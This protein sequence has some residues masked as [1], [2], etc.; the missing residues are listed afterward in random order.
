VEISPLGE[1]DNHFPKERG[2]FKKE[3]PKKQH[4]E[5]I[6]HAKEEEEEEPEELKPIE[7]KTPIKKQ[8]VGTKPSNEN[9]SGSEN[10][11]KKNSENS[12]N[13]KSTS[14]KSIEDSYNPEDE[15]I[16][17]RV[18][19]DKESR[20]KEQSKSSLFLKKIKLGKEEW[21]LVRFSIL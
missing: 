9:N 15:S 11:S 2:H 5:N 8:N 21:E 19:K 1:H 13:E 20:Y 16:Q 4:I 3:E 18:W 10:N 14:E 17:P 6:H 12:K 7:K